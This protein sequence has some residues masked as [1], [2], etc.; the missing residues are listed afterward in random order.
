[1]FNKR[2]NRVND[3]PSP[4]EEERRR[5]TMATYTA[6]TSEDEAVTAFVGRSSKGDKG[7]IVPI[8][9]E[10][11]ERELAIQTGYKLTGSE[12][13]TYDTNE[14]GDTLWL[15]I[16]RGVNCSGNVKINDMEWFPEKELL[17]KG[18]IDQDSYKA[19]MKEAKEQAAKTKQP[20]DEILAALMPKDNMTYSTFKTLFQWGMTDGMRWDDVLG[21]RVPIA[22][23]P[24]V[25][26][27]TPAKHISGI[28]TDPA[29]DNI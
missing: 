15:Q 21:E 20:V 5:Y 2:F 9:V 29:I 17:P 1:M 10:K 4:V 7:F 8:P 11:F 18:I 14:N 26:F 28:N 12:Y 27:R 23:R 25:E 3:E 24:A 16:Q 22:H 6:Y 19:L 13:I